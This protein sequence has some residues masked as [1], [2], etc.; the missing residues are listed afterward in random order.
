MK[1]FKKKEKEPSEKVKLW[2]EYVEFTEN[3]I[4]QLENSIII[5]SAFLEKGKEELKKAKRA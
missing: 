3:R 2:Q 4:K 5:E 1:M